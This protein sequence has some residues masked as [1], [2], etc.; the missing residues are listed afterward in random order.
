MA[1]LKQP[2]VFNPDDGDSYTNWKADVEV[3]RL[4]STDTKIKQGP[5]VYLSLH[6]DAREACRSIPASEL[7][8]NAGLDKVLKEL[9]S[10][11]LKDE[12][13]RAF[14]AIRSFIDFRREGGQTFP[15]FLV[16]FNNRY[17]EV[18]KYKLKFEDGIL[19]YFL[20]AAANISEDHE[21]LVRA[22]SSLTFEDMKDKLQKVFGEFESDREGGPL[23]IKEDCLYTGHNRGRG[24]GYQQ[25]GYFRRGT[26]P[27]RGSTR[28]R[29][30]S[31]RDNPCNQGGTQMR[32][33]ECDSTKHFVSD[34][35]HRNYQ[36]AKMLVHLTLVT[37]DFSNNVMMLETLAKAILD[38]ACTKTVTGQI[39]LNEFLSLLPTWKQ[40][41]V[42]SSKKSTSTLYRFGDGVKT[43]S[44]Y[45]IDI[46]INVC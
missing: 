8:E 28:G 12:T 38:T 22:T 10:V 35:P 7:A 31:T 13:T 1:S 41:Q 26:F 17:R 14:C 43:K 6:G 37:G 46:P 34:C 18:T 29:D 25:R 36:N 32:C 30:W 11:F 5:A 9:D 42:N 40:D 23:P 39:W 3:W 2:P 44:N 33:H 4:L 20:L 24:R 21:R 15:K 16:E 19:A 27:P 45:E